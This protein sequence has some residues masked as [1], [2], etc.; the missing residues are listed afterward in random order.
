MLIGLF[1][2]VLAFYVLV[3]PVPGSAGTVQPGVSPA[4]TVPVVTPS[5]P[6]A[7]AGRQ[8]RPGRPIAL[9]QPDTKLDPDADGDSHAAL[10]CVPTDD[11]RTS[12]VGRD[13]GARGDLTP[14]ASRPPSRSEPGP[15]R[16]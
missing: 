6:P 2:G 5:L 8:A 7:L 9:G 11:A 16:E 15:D 4:T 10:E 14:G 13:P 1:L 12:L 3:R